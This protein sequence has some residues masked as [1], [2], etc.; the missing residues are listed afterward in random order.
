MKKPVIAALIAF[1]MTACIGTGIFTIGGAALF[2]Q[3]SSPASNSPAQTL[4]LNT[5]G[6]AGQ[7]SQLQ[8]QIAQYQQREQEYQQRE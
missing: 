4:D 7:V 5:T 3:N 6:Q 1:L 2:N 8:N